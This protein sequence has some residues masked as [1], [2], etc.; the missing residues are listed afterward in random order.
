MMM[1][2]IVF[3]GQLYVHMYIFIFIYMYV[4]IACIQVN[5]C[6]HITI[7]YL[8]YFLT[9]EFQSITAPN[10]ICQ[11]SNVTIQCVILRNG[12]AL[13]T[14]WQRNGVPVI[15]DDTNY[16]LLFNDTFNADTDFLIINIT[17]EDDNTEYMCSNAGNNIV[18]L[19]VLNVTGMNIYLVYIFIKAQMNN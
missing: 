14:I 13:D 1:I 5:A 17:S 16:D 19:V 2:S 12:V 4:Y 8:V 6:I 10:T 3:C 7:L 18:G 9:L 11:G 15:I